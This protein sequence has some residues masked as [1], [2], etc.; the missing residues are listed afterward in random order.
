M[1]WL[2]LS[3]NTHWLLIYDNYDNPQL[4]GDKDESTLDLLRF[5]PDSDHGSI[6]ITTRLSR[7][8]LGYRIQV[9]KLVDTHDSLE[10]L[11][12]ASGRRGIM[13]DPAAVE[14]TKELDGLP[15]ALSTAGAYLEQVTTTFSEYLR[16][17]KA[18]WLKLQ[19]TSPQLT[20]YEDRSLHTT[21]QL[22][23][24]QI[25]R[26]NV[27]SARL[28]KLWAYFDRHDVW[29]ELLQHGYSADND[30]M[31]S[32]VEDIIS[33]GTAVRILCNYGLVDADPS[34]HETVGS[35]GYSMHSCVHS[36]TVSVLN[37]D[38]DESL[39][40][41][42]LTC[43]ALEVPDSN[44]NKWWLL[45]RR[46]LAHATRHDNFVAN[47]KVNT[48]GMEWTLHNLS[49]LY[50][51]QG[52]LAEA[53]RMYMRA[54]QGYEEALR[55]KH[56]STLGTV[57]NLGLL[58]ADQGK[59]AEAEG[60]YMRALQGYEEALRP[61]HTSTLG[62]VNNLGILYKN[63]GKLA[64]AEEMYMRALQ[65]KEEA[66]GPKH[67]STLQTVNN[68]GILYK[69]QGKLAEAEGMY[70]RALQGYEEAFG[71][72]TSS[73]VLVLNTT[74]NLGIL[75][76]ETKREDM[77]IIMY[78]KA[79]SGFAAAQGQTSKICREIEQ[80]IAALEIEQAELEVINKPPILRALQEP[81]SQL[82]RSF[83]KLRLKMRK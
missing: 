50:A 52:K 23:L 44:E 25:E 13:D 4:S 48:A 26:Q 51:D 31:Q 54:L 40:R 81:K 19:T 49:S 71:T 61:K 30:W 28:L 18:S 39:A 59:L 74:Y 17:Y 7:V 6:I 10:I 69:N 53:E 12:N 8:A 55:P 34:L 79:L 66:L 57:N 24:D 9:K 70:M 76:A 45:Q 14:L 29:F 5:L 37:K 78:T 72:N 65:G 77:A 21:W 46:L 35:G 73:Y 20:S 11:S 41:L 3:K 15:L 47:G 38:W 1:N 16:L 63:Q 83:K 22:S 56:T 36:W 60:M 67:T 62:T 82:H 68:L 75:Y 64:E 2:N 43:I 33:F 80:Q 42:A 32:L 58:Y 27:L